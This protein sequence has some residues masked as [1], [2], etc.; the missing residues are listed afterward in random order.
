MITTIID[1][2]IPFIA[3]D[4]LDI[5]NLQQISTHKLDLTLSEAIRIRINNCRDFLGQKR[6]NSECLFYGINTGSGFV[7]NIAI[8]KTQIAQLK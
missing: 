8:D 4:W 7:Q 1:K 6:N 5:D 3:Q 2:S